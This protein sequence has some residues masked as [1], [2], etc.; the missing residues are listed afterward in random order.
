MARRPLPH[1]EV[2][3]TDLRGLVT[4]DWHDFF[5]SLLE[6][7]TGGGGGG[8]GGGGEDWINVKSHGAHGND[9]NDDTSSVTAAINLALSTNRALY[10]PPGTY[11]ITSPLPV[12]G[13]SGIYG[14]GSQDTILKC[15][16][17][18]GDF[19]T[20]A[21][22][23]NVIRDIGFRAGVTRTDG[24]MVRMQG[25]GGVID[26]FFID[27]GFI[28]LHLKGPG[29]KATNGTV[30]N[31]T[32]HATAPFSGYISLD[33]LGSDTVL[34]NITTRNDNPYTSWPFFG[35]VMIDGAY[36]LANCDILQA[37]NGVMVLPAAAGK[38]VYLLAANCWFDTHRDHCAVI[39]PGAGTTVGSAN[40]TGCQFGASATASPTAANGV[41]IIQGAGASLGNV[42][43]DNCLFLQYKQDFGS[44]VAMSATF[45]DQA[46]KVSNSMLG[47][48]D[49][50][51]FNGVAIG[52]G[53]AGTGFRDW[54]IIGNEI[55][56]Q[57]TIGNTILVSDGSD[58][59]IIADNRLYPF[60]PSNF[61]APGNWL[62]TDNIVIP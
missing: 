12:I 32:S 49:A 33:G 60:A 59:F 21:G 10:F 5:R 28:G 2:A 27:G 19:V 13:S 35:V 36:Q 23:G 38:T 18:T 3:I 46:L 6:I 54:D 20:V 26:S 22:N 9:S 56:A 41:T 39:Q 58:R 42:S 1:P 47:T 48:R 15:Y 29:N 51:F 24:A 52:D 55:H 4:R 14:S 25:V 61:A 31:A 50:N 8:G 62:I 7:V 34:S 40:F 57:A 30:Q 17:A 37:I 53:S 45:A 16:F 11:K 44:A 43:I